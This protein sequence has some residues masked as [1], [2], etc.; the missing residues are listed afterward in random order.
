MNDP[1]TQGIDYFYRGHPLTRW[2]VRASLRVRRRLYDWLTARLGGVRGKVFLEHGSTPDTERADSNCFIRWLLA[3]GAV[4]YAA[5]LEDIRHLT[6]A[7][8]G[9]QILPLPLPAVSLPR[10]DCVI[11]SAVL[12]HAGARTCQQALLTDLIRLGD[13]ILVTTPNRWH[14]LEFHTKLPLLHW[15]PP[16]WHRAVLKGLGLRFWADEDNLN[17][18]SRAALTQ[19]LEGAAA[20]AGRQ[21]DV[22][23][24]RPRFAGAVSNLVVLVTPHAA[25][26]S[27]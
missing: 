18:L 7:F 11:S 15:L 21:I 25:A 13:P 8:P 2:Q 20:A 4:V 27:T 14:W 16:R 9:L 1:E 10:F 26:G 17:L 23:W 6:S 19:L 12:E 24:F 22:A 5:S 3:D